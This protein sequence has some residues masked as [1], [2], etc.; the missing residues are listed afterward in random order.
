MMPSKFFTN[1]SRGKFIERS[2]KIRIA[3]LYILSF[4]LMAGYANSQAPE[5]PLVPNFTLA[6]LDGKTWSVNENRGSVLILNF[7][8]TW[9]QPCRTEIPYLV[10]LGSEFKNRDVRIAGITLDE[11]G[12][13]LVRKFFVEY[14]INYPILLPEPGSPL[15][16]TENVPM[17]LL[18]GRD[19]RLVQRYTGAVPEKILRQ[20]IEKLVGQPK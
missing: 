5:K 19:G 2:M 20:D 15:L 16:K 13:E 6:T 9:C 1:Q 14:K 10:K 17:T 4:C 3:A 18:I 8:A 11:G 7:W 12:L